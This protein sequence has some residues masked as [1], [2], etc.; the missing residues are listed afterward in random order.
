[1]TKEKRN[2]AVVEMLENASAREVGKVFGI[3]KQR[4]CKIAKQ[5]G[6]DLSPRTGNPKDGI[7]K[8]SNL[9]GATTDT[10]IV[11]QVGVGIHTVGRLRKRLK[12][13]RYL[14]PIGCSKCKTNHYAKGL[15]RN[16]YARNNYRQKQR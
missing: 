1:M 6:L 4:V 11:D 14:L 15:C 2:L 16:C 13:G 12:I 9:L 10:E 7:I 3:S 5:Y 8:E